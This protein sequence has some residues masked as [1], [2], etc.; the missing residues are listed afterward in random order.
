MVE[1]I[2]HPDPLDIGGQTVKNTTFSEH[3]LVAQQIKGNH[4]CS[5]MV[6]IFYPQ[7]TPPP[8]MGVVSKGQNSTI[9][10]HGHVAYQIKGNHKCSKLVASI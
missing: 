3:G 7:T 4:E 2:L 8:T 9:P 6:A 10:E 5:N 1:N